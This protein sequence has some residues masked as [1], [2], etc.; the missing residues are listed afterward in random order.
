MK[1]RF[2]TSAGNHVKEI[3][4]K[5]NLPD[6]RSILTDSKIYI[7]MV[8][9]CRDEDTLALGWAKANPTSVMAT[10]NID[11]LQ[12]HV[13]DSFILSDKDDTNGKALLVCEVHQCVQHGEGPKAD[14]TNSYA[15]NIPNVKTKV[16]TFSKETNIR[17][18]IS[19]L[20]TSSGDCNEDSLRLLLSRIAWVAQLKE[21]P[22]KLWSGN[23]FRYNLRTNGGYLCMSD[24]KDDN[25]YHSKRICIHMKSDRSIKDE[26]NIMHKEDIII[27]VSRKKPMTMV[28]M[29]VMDNDSDMEE[30]RGN[31]SMASGHFKQSECPKTGGLI[32]SLLEEVVKVGQVMGYR[33]E[34]CMANMEEIIGV[35]GVEDTI[36]MNWKMSLNIQGSIILNGSPTEEF[37][38]GKGLKQGDPLSPFLF[39]LIMESLHLSFQRVVDAGLFHGVK[40]R[41]TVTFSHLFYAA[42]GLK[43]NMCKSKILGIHVNN[44]NI[45]RAAEDLGCQV[46]KLPFSY[47]GSMVGGRMH[48]LHSWD[49][50]VDRVRNRLSKWKMKMLSSGGRLTLVKSVLGSMPIF[51]MSLFK[52]P[53]GEI[54]LKKKAGWGVIEPST[55][56]IEYYVQMGFEVS[57]PSQGKGIKLMN[58]LRITLGNGVLRG[59][60]TSPVALEDKLVAQPD[61]GIAFISQA[62]QEVVLKNAQFCEFLFLQQQVASRQGTDRWTWNG[63]MA[64]VISVSPRTSAYPLGIFHDKAQTPLTREVLGTKCSSWSSET[65]VGKDSRNN[66]ATWKL[67]NT[68][69]MRFQYSV[70]TLWITHTMASNTNSGERRSIEELEG[71]RWHLKPPEQTLVRVTILERK[72]DLDDD[73]RVENVLVIQGKTC[74]KQQEFIDC[75]HTTWDENLPTIEGIESEWGKPISSEACLVILKERVKYSME[76]MISDARVFIVISKEKVDTHQYQCYGPRYSVEESL[77]ADIV[78]SEHERMKNGH[79]TILAISVEDITKDMSRLTVPNATQKCDLCGPEISWQNVNCQQKTASKTREEKDSHNEVKLLKT[80]ERK[81]Q[82]TKCK[83]LIEDSSQSVTSENKACRQKKEEIWQSKKLFYCEEKEEEAEVQFSKEEFPPLGNTHV[84]R[85]CVKSEVHYSGNATARANFLRSMKGGI[86]IDKDDITIYKKV[87]KIKTSN[88]TEIVEIAELEVSEEEFHR[89][90]VETQDTLERTTTSTGKEIFTKNY[91]TPEEPGALY[92]RYQLKANQTPIRVDKSDAWRSVAQDLELSASKEAVKA[93]QNTSYSYNAKPQIC[94][95]NPHRKDNIGLINSRRCSSSNKEPEESSSNW[96]PGHKRL[97]A[98]TIYTQKM[99]QSKTMVSTATTGKGF[100]EDDESDDDSILIVDPGWDDYSSSC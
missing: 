50:T 39:I 17:I 42:S 94:Y 67:P 81:G 47:L 6:H 64:Q 53:V 51:H 27:K 78:K 45:S 76:D 11:I 52:V 65:L 59:Y 1:F 19:S 40:L 89:D 37:E 46:L 35:K 79:P 73:E 97:E 85:P 14:V 3:L 5:L 83:Q 9:E 82:T 99:M 60:G 54:L 68:S 32:L 21:C 87:T 80:F 12:S 38:F 71:M 7:K 26:F 100:L 44:D 43:I 10:S 15:Q 66:Y 55:P 69:Y 62:A 96:K 63:R 28:S 18:G 41:D 8:M 91:F 98:I 84:A 77:Y 13:V 36:T 56:K 92:K 88:Q 2:D 34:G 20:A 48:R 31:E 93:M 49:D 29:I 74:T 23:T 24:T 90:N 70:E 33:M 61:M 58:Y 16:N 95:G 22:F 75:Y 4:L 86:R 30:E 57:N 72:S 25:C